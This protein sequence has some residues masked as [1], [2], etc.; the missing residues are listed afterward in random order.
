[1]LGGDG[2]YVGEAEA[3][4]V[5]GG[6]GEGF[7]V[8]FV[9]PPSGPG[10][11]TNDP[12]YPY[13]TNAEAARTG[14]QPTYRVADLG[15]PILKPWAVERMRKANAE[16]IAGKIRWNAR[17]NCYPGGVPQFLIYGA[18]AACMVMLV[19]GK[20]HVPFWPTIRWKG[21]SP[22]APARRRRRD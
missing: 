8:D 17:S 19:E 14:R 7:G 20:Y 22:E 5:F 9:Q 11:V 12:A 18:V 3:P 13:L 16:V 21:A 10:P 1:M 15:N 6:G 2:L 4:E